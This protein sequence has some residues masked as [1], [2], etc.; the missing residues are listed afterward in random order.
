MKLFE[1]VLFC[2]FS[3]LSTAQ[4]ELKEGGTYRWTRIMSNELNSKLIFSKNDSLRNATF[5]TSLYNKVHDGKIELYSDTI[6]AG[7]FGE[8]KV[9]PRNK[10]FMT[11]NRPEIFYSS[12]IV[13]YVTSVVRNDEPKKDASGQIIYKYNSSG[14]KYF[15]FDYT[16]RP[17]SF[18]D[19]LEIKIL[20]KGKY[21]RRTQSIDFEPLAIA[22]QPEYAKHL[23]WLKWSDINR[24]CDETG[25]IPFVEAIKNRKY[26]GFQ[27]RQ[28]GCLNEE[29]VFL[30]KERWVKIDKNQ[31]SN[32]LFSSDFFEFVVN[33]TNTG[34]INTYFNY[35]IHDKWKYR[36]EYVNFDIP[37]FDT[38]SIENSVNDSILVRKGILRV[39]NQADT[40][41]KIDEYG[42]PQPDYEDNIYIFFDQNYITQIRI[43]EKMSTTGSK[44]EFVPT[45]ILFVQEKNGVKRE[46]FI[47][48]LHELK[49]NI[50]QRDSHS[51]YDYIFTKQYDGFIYKQSR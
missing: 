13:D 30:P 29:K 47:L 50:E 1:L 35:K 11:A 3:F 5:F 45:S 21:S 10:Y 18:D 8:W 36:W 37:I 34:K 38:T 7:N 28:E 44:D 32:D 24:I 20:E 27:Y 48:D 14:E 26:D 49:S 43:Q 33:A 25:T 9:I 15:E 51:W 31:D 17:L 39:D 40:V 46:L 23:F 42:M 4:V 2:F 22:F 16:T 41:Y 19:V 12:S 6:A